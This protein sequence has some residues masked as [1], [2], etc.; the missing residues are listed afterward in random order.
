MAEEEQPLNTKNEIKEQETIAPHAI[1]KQNT[2]KQVDIDPTLTQITCGIAWDFIEKKID[3]D[4]TI[5]V[6]DTY[7]WEIDAAYYNQT[8]ILNGAIIHSGDD[9]TGI[10]E[11]DNEQI[12][13]NLSKLPQKCKSLWFIVNAFSGGS[14]TDVETARF[15]LY[16]GT[17]HSKILYSYGVGMAFNSTALLLGVL[18][19]NDPYAQNKNWSFKMIEAKGTGHN[20][21]ESKYVLVENLNIIYDEGILMERPADRHQKY[22]LTKGD[23]Y[24][25]DPE[26]RTVF[27]GLGW[28]SDRERIDVDASVLIFNILYNRS[29]KNFLKQDIVSFAHKKYK[30]SVIHGGDNRTGSV[31]SGDDEVIEIDLDRLNADD[32]ADILCV[33]INIFTSGYSFNNIRNCFA[34]LFDDR[35]KELCRFNLTESYNTEAMIM[36]HF[37]KRKNGCWGMITDGVGCVGHTAERCVDDAI[38][39]I[40]GV[41]ISEKDTHDHD[42]SERERLVNTQNN[43]YNTITQNTSKK[44][45][46]CCCC[47]VL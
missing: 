45:S 16:N 19:V 13:I 23:T 11:G 18:S 29:G 37:E 5:V 22:E 12:K 30:N 9:K 27:V 1:E 39:V 15:T 32:E 28:D 47:V 24:V 42:M 2:I 38:K 43:N 41:K 33:V 26:L 14:F 31:G 20:F 10:S 25:I 36:C 7:S 8:S 3:L 46:S 44:K 4:V 40:K 34:R 17:N 35:N 21:V 6:L